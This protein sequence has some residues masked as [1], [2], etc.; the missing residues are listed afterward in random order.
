MG[1]L[2]GSFTVTEHNFTMSHIYS[3]HFCPDYNS[4]LLTQS[5][6]HGI[7]DCWSQYDQPGVNLYS[8]NCALVLLPSQPLSF[9][10]TPLRKTSALMPYSATSVC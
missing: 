9:I 5:I 4:L 7:S 8:S 1:Y 3:I 6:A 10:H 2:K